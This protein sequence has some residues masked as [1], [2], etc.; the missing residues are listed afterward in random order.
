MSSQFA[1][2][3]EDEVLVFNATNDSL[4]VGVGS[5]AQRMDGAAWEGLTQVS[6]V[7]PPCPVLTRPAGCPETRQG[8]VLGYPPLTHAHWGMQVAAMLHGLPHALH[9]QQHAADEAAGGW[10]MPPVAAPVSLMLAVYPA[11]GSHYARHLD[12]DPTDGR[13]V[14]RVDTSWTVHHTTHRTARQQWAKHSCP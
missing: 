11:D 1:Q 9:A 2:G 14:P 6:P 4:V 7:A 3:R 13:C 10:A 12:N 5:T 8:G